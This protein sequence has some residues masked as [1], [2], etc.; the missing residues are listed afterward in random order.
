MNHSEFIPAIRFMVV[1]DIHIKDEPTVE[2]ER[3]AKAIETAYKISESSKTYKNLDAIVID[4]DFA[5]SG[6]EIQMQAAKKILDDGM[7]YN[8]TKLII[9]VAS[10][11]FSTDG[12]DGAYNKLKNIFGCGPDNHVV[13]NGFHFVSVSPSKSCNYNDEKK[14]WVADELQKAAETDRKKPIFMFQHPHNSGTVYGSILWGEDD[15]ISTYM[16]YPQIIDFSG[17]S[18][19]PINDPRSV[20][21][22]HFTSFGTGTLSYFELD[23]F[24][25]ICG[26]IPENSKLAAQMLIVEADAQNRVRVYPYDLITDHYFPYTWKI[27]VP[28]DPSTFTYTNQRYKTDVCPYFDANAKIH[29]VD[30]GSDSATVEFDQANIDEDYVN[31]YD[32]VVKKAGCGCIVKQLSIW[33]EYYFY[34]MPKA[35]RVSVDSLEP[36]TEYFISVTANSFWYTKSKEAL[37]V[38]IKTK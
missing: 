12:V 13:I 15:L 11:E 17:H 9:S 22:Q 29:A 33:S 35:L 32:I 6:T 8:K 1:S 37:S 18:H 34:D 38:M 30:I 31:S 36:N 4:G 10:H 25:K 21:Q 14:K 16:N 26:T 23:E 24:D 3:F 5:N 28:S 19:A 27:D 2:R 20:H 7:D